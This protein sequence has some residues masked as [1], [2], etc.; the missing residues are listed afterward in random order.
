[1]IRDRRSC[2]ARYL[3]SDRRIAALSAP[4]FR[5]SAVQSGQTCMC[6]STQT[7]SAKSSS[8]SSM[9]WT[10]LSYQRNSSVAL[11][12]W[13]F[14]HAASD[15]RPAGVS[16]R[17]QLPNPNRRKLHDL[18]IAKDQHLPERQGLSETRRQSAQR[19]LDNSLRPRQLSLAG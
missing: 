4:C 17:R 6:V 13:V 14:S 7:A 19:R 15:D 12:S 5:Y 18:L 8:W 9:P 1:M 3:G 2:G 10:R 16:Q 11:L